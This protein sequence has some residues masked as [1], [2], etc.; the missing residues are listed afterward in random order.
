MNLPGADGL[1][2]AIQR[3]INGVRCGKKKMKKKTTPRHLMLPFSYN[4]DEHNLRS[5]SAHAHPNYS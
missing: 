1:K 5:R 3:V 2:G 4:K